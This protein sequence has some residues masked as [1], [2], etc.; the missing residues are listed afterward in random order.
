MDTASKKITVYNFL[1]T[2]YKCFRRIEYPLLGDFSYGQLL[3]QTK[4]GQDYFFVELID[5]MTFKFICDFLSSKTG[6]KIGKANP[7]KILALLADKV[8]GKE[9]TTDYPI[10]PKCKR[11]QIWY[12]DNNRTSKRQIGF[13]SWVDFENL[14]TEAKENKLEHII[15][16][17]SKHLY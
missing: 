15:T 16:S 5:N 10:C 8:N 12:N 3:F 17:N 14:S 13:A 9:F 6:V 4:D 2:C 11:K 1:N 7:Q